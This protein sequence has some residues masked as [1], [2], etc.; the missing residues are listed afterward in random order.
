VVQR[1]GKNHTTQRHKDTKKFVGFV[2]FSF[3]IYRRYAALGFVL[4]L[5]LPY[6][7]R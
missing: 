5:Q 1:H 4:A 2:P 3:K 6:Y 7:R